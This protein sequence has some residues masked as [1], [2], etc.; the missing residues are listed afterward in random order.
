[1]VNSTGI[2]SRFSKKKI[3]QTSSLSLASYK[4]FEEF[5]KFVPMPEYLI[6]PVS[7]L[8]ELNW[9][10]WI[11]ATL[12]PGN[13]IL[14]KNVNKLPNNYFCPAFRMEGLPTVANVQKIDQNLYKIREPIA[15]YSKN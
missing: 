1:M 3:L 5:L 11:G 14:I 8:L 4:N 12:N 13:T 2:F 6:L 15:H 7:Y 9:N 10:F